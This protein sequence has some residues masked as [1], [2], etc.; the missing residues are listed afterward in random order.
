MD[1]RCYDLHLVASFIMGILFILS[2]IL[3]ASTCEYNGVFS[4]VLSG[5]RCCGDRRFNV[6]VE[7]ERGS[8]TVGQIV[9]PSE[10]DHLL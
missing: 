8:Q 10:V 7:V 4:F 6:E 3:G 1:D 5:M 9:R 2:E